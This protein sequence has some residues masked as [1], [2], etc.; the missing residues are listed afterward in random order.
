MPETHIGLF[1]DVGGGW[2]LSRCTGRLGEYLALTGHVMRAA[3]AL[4]AGLADVMVPAA[5]LG[6]LR[7]ALADAA[8]RPD[9]DVRKV[10]NRFVVDPPAAILPAARDDIDQHFAA[11][12]LAG[13]FRSLEEAASAWAG[14]TLESLKECS[15]LMMA[16][17]LELVRR[18]RTLDLAQDLRLE[19]DLVRNC[20]H[21]RPGAAS[22]TV[23]GIRALAVDKDHKPR[24]SPALV[25]AVTSRHVEVFFDSPWPA[26]AHPL[27]HLHA[28]TTKKA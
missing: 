1:P 20:F 7:Q 6:S 27:R 2:F 15:P 10:A 3:D 9:I 8:M 17:T 19:R 12:D 22:E 18:A 5:Q 16:V 4:W 21:L 23:E 13:I 25:E 28:G 14:S 24:W 26:H 11:D